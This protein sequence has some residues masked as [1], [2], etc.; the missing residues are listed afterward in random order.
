MNEG[1]FTDEMV[2][3]YVVSLQTQAGIQKYA[4]AIAQVLAEAGRASSKVT[5]DAP[6]TGTRKWASVILDRALQI[7]SEEQHELKEKM[8]KRLTKNANT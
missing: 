7:L 8:Q 3:H 1:P 2:K 5:G 4:E 6:S